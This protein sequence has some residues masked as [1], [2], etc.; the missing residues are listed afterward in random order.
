MGHSVV[1]VGSECCCSERGSE[2]E[3][4]YASKLLYPKESN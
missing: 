2:R 3:K 1:E 4:P